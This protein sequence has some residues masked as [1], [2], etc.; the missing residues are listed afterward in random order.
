[1]IKSL[2][3]T[4]HLG[5]SIVLELMRPEKSGFVVKS[6]DGLG[7]VKATVNMTSSA[8]CDGAMFNSAF[9]NTRDIQLSLLYYQTETETIECIRQKS[10]KYFPTKKKIHLLIETDN[11]VVQTEGYVESN[12]PNIF[13]KDSGCVIT[14]ACPDPYLYSLYESNTIFYGVEPLFEFPLENAS[15]N[16]RLLELGTIIHKSTAVVLYEG[17][18]D[19][20]C[21]I[22]IDATGPVSSG[23]YIYRADSSEKMIIDTSKL[24]SIVGS[25]IING[26]TIIIE[27]GVGK[28]SIVL[29]RDNIR[30][31]ILN[32]L[33]KESTW[34]TL[35]K[36]DNI[37]SYTIGE[38]AENVQF[39]ITNKIVYYGV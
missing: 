9:I 3:I 17:D 13:S 8:T 1:M 27:T 18:C 14:I 29:I 31:N 28:K 38:G 35:F 5:D 6:I 15:L 4:N 11:R 24:I 34:F 12:E 30:Y 36:G 22:Y 32:C 20:G 23:I 2:T 26:D 7:P 39:R 19:I 21:T 16:E 10:Y 25:E 37:F 33:T